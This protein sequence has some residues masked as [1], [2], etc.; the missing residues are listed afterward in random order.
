MPKIE[1]RI[2]YSQCC[3]ISF[4]QLQATTFRSRFSYTLQLLCAVA[5]LLS[6]GESKKAVLLVR[7]ATIEIV[8]AVIFTSSGLAPPTVTSI[9][10]TQN[11]GSSPASTTEVGSDT[12]AGSGENPCGTVTSY[13]LRVETVRPTDTQTIYN[14]VTIIVPAVTSTPISTSGTVSTEDEVTLETSSGA[15]TSPTATSSIIVIPLFNTTRSSVAFSSTTT[16][17]KTTETS[18][19]SSSSTPCIQVPTHCVVPNTFYLQATGISTAGSSGTNTLL[20]RANCQYATLYDA[21]DGY[22]E[23]FLTFSQP[24]RD[25]ATAFTLDSQSRLIGFSSTYIMIVNKLGSSNPMYFTAPDTSATYTH[26]AATNCSISASDCS[27]SC[28]YGIQTQMSLCFGN[29]T[30]VVD[31]NC[32][33]Y[34]TSNVTGQG[35]SCRGVKPIAVAIPVNGFK[36]VIHDVRG[37]PHD[38]EGD[39]EDAR[40]NNSRMVKV[41]LLFGRFICLG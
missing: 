37:L 26:Y 35:N 11:L 8:I 19:R 36:A 32:H 30:N 39:Q 5:G 41:N 18:S 2:V 16:T 22:R 6:A 25:N 38:L 40:W 10:M 17:S 24:G 12:G 1:S 20:P 4:L 34:L 23:D 33:L 15:I 14:T 9:T 13:S 29:A 28:A 3:R 7:R 21:H 27:L 31:A